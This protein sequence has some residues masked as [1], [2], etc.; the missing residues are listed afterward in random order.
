MPASRTT[1]LLAVATEQD[2]RD[3]LARLVQL[4]DG[5]GRE[6]LGSANRGASPCGGH[7]SELL[8]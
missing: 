1:S 4:P 3:P 6:L 8:R 7:H 5:D 2:V